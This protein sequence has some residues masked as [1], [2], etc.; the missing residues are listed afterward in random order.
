MYND[1][2][3]EIKSKIMYSGYIIHPVATIFKEFYDETC[4]LI[5]NEFNLETLQYNEISFYDY[6][7]SINYFNKIT[8]TM[9]DIEEII[10]LHMYIPQD[11]PDSD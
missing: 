10:L 6:L 8:F 2:P 3:I 11:A 9:E 7:Y 1:L 5:N 4:Y